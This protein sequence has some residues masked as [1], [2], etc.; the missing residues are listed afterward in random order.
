MSV[1]VAGNVDIRTTASTLEQQLQ[2]ALTNSLSLGDIIAAYAPG[3]YEILLAG[4]NRE[5]VGATQ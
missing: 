3:E 5:R 1:A 4:A 2:E